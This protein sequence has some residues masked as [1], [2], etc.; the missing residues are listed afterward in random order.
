VTVADGQKL[1]GPE[2]ATAGPPHSTAITVLPPNPADHVAA[3]I[4]E[5]TMSER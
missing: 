2:R 1:D 3:N 5:R 4:Q